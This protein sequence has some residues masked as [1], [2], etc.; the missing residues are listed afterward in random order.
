MNS[1]KRTD[2]LMTLGINKQC[3]TKNRA[4]NDYYATPPE[5]VDWLLKYE[6]FNK[7]IWECMCGEGFISERLKQRGFNVKSSDIINYGYKD[8]IIQD[9]K[10]CTKKFNGDIISN[11]PYK[12]CIPMTLKAIELAEQKVAFLMKIQFLET[13]ERHKK[14]FNQ[15]PPSKIYAFTKRIS[16]YKNG[17]TNYTGS[18]MFYCWIIWDKQHKG[19]TTFNWIPNYKKKSSM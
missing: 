12:E 14:I 19:P 6:T 17:Q 18:A 9:F 11:P 5:A 1:Y 16:C 8:T 3:N 2:P 7:N 10:K 13:I 4:L 15:H